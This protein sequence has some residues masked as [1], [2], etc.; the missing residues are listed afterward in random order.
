[1]LRED[2]DIRT[3]AQNKNPPVQVYFSGSSMIPSRRAANKQAAVRSAGV[4]GL[5]RCPSP[6]SQ[7]SDFLKLSRPLTHFGK[8][9]ST[10][11]APPR[12]ASSDA[13]F[14]PLLAMRVFPSPALLTTADT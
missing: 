3:V 12:R 1:M 5:R 7:L 9:G 11:S 2:P 14:P 6:R 13:P 10:T 4:P 8:T